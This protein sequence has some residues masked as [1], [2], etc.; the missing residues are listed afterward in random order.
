M[1]RK[2]ATRIKKLHLSFI[3]LALVRFSK[4]WILLISNHL[5]DNSCKDFFLFP[6]FYP[7]QLKHIRALIITDDVTN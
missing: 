4:L 1:S 3:P 2:T 6:S 5:D 7:F